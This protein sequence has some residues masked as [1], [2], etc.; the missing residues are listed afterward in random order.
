MQ[1]ETL[2]QQTSRTKREKNMER[3]RKGTDS[4][5]TVTVCDART[6][7][8]FTPFFQLDIHLPSDMDY[9]IIK[10]VTD[11]ETKKKNHILPNFSLVATYPHGQYTDP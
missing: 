3:E 4:I 6:G 8:D 10:K 9:V 2:W 11:F 7:N 1:S 5:S